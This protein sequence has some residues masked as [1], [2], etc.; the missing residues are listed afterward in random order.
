ML[1]KEVMQP[2]GTLMI[3]NIIRMSRDHEI[4]LV[5]HTKAGNSFEGIFKTLMKIDLAGTGERRALYLRYEAV[6]TEGHALIPIDR[7]DMIGF[8]TD[9]GFLDDFI[10]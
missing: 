8:S 3:D 2:K 1:A 9:V 7:I 4:P 10:E 5:I 6:G